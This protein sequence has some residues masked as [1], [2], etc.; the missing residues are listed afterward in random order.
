MVEIIVAW[1]E[2]ILSVHHFES[3][4]KEITIGSDPKADIHCPNLSGTPLYTLLDIK[5][6]PS[7]FISKGIQVSL[8]DHKNQYSAEKLSQQGLITTYG[9]RQVL[10]LSQG[11]L[12]CL[13]FASALNVYIRYAN[14]VQKALATGLFNFNFSEMMGIMMSFFF[15]SMLIFYVA[16]FSPQFLDSKED[17]EEADIKKATIEFKQKKRVVKLQMTNKAQKKKTKLS[18]PNKSKKIKKTK[19]VGIKK[20]GKEGRLGQVAA[21]PKA[22][23]KKKTVTSARSGRSVHTKAKKAGQAQK[24]LAQTPLK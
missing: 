8:R 12:I 3:S 18:I 19:K 14:R 11:Q 7:V 23:S 16:I 22:K 9:S 5:K 24:A 20:P 21:K 4:A 6:N 15:M 2:R 10:S 1:K 13:N 17:L